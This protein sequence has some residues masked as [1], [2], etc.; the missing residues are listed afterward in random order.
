MTY[1]LTGPRAAATAVTN[2]AADASDARDLLLALGLIAPGTAPEGEPETPAGAASGRTARPRQ[3]AR[4][5][6][7]LADGGATVGEIAYVL[8]ATEDLAADMLDGHPAGV[9]W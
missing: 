4:T 6:S 2:L 1:H 7:L 9:Q 3:W 5:A 8:G